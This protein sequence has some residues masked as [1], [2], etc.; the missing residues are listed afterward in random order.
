MPTTH[1]TA[2]Y[3]FSIQ[4]QDST[5]LAKNF[6]TLWNPANSGKNMVLGSFFTSYMATVASPT[7][8]LR[9]YRIFDQPTGGTLA[10]ASEICAFDTKVFSPVAEIRYN[11]PTIG[12]L[13][14]AIFNS[15]PGIQ[16]GQ[17]ESSIIEQIDAPAP[18]NPFLV[19][20]GEGVVMRQDQGAPGHYW[21]L[22]I[23]WREL[24]G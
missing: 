12:P 10:A 14:G 2:L 4:R 9:G 17:N 16:Q 5:V 20:P 6:L 21:N 8:P 13:D 24:H 11:N 19:R 23:V 22:S 1:T 18:F 15:P 3:V 7:Y